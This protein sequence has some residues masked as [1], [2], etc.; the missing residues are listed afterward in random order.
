MFRDR[1]ANDILSEYRD[2]MK[3]ICPSLTPVHPSFDEYDSIDN[4]HLVDIGS[5]KFTPSSSRKSTPDKEKPSTASKDTSLYSSDIENILT[6]PQSPVF[7]N[8]FLGRLFMD[9]LKSPYWKTEMTK[10]IDKK[11]FYMRKP[12]FLEEIHVK[13]LDM[14]N[15]MPL[16]ERYVKAILFQTMELMQL[17]GIMECGMF[18]C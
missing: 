10:L 4:S 18:V 17:S 15:V 7:L 5:S 13:T 6:I 2:F 12:K 1:Q 9:F 3:R 14:G 16:I 11:L 8:A